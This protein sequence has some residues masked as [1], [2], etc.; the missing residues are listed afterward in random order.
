MTPA[1]AVS[2][3]ALLFTIASFWW[4][5]ARRGK[6]IMSGVPA[7]S[8]YI[9]SDARLDIRLPVVLYNTGARTRL[10]DELRLVFPSW[11]ESHADWQTFHPTLGPRSDGTDTDDFAGPCPIDGR[12]A[13]ARF[14]EFTLR[15]K[16]ELPEPKS[17]Q[18]R[19]EARLDGSMS[20]SPLGSFTLC[21]GHMAY[22]SSYVTYRNSVIPCDGEPDSTLKTWSALAATRGLATPWANRSSIVGAENEGSDP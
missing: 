17:T 19:V 16:G 15:L 4:L 14:V 8:G 12:R 5:Q 13:V 3:T 7:F 6:L 9:A 21:L 2:I 18:C 22:P 20:W 10:V 1:L 11:A